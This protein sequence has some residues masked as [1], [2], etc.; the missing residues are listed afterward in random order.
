MIRLQAAAL[1]VVISLGA[2]PA[3]AQAVPPK[4]KTVAKTTLTLGTSQVAVQLLEARAYFD[5]LHRE[6]RG[7]PGIPTHRLILKSADRGKVPVLKRVSASGPKGKLEGFLHR[8]AGQQVADVELRAPG[9]YTFELVTTTGAM[10][11]WSR[12]VR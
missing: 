7:H 8:E 9:R 3:L 1:A 2:S 12:T 10:A 5:D 6:H 4:A 11:R